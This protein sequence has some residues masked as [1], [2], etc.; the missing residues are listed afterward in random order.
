MLYT[1][2]MAGVFIVWFLLFGVLIIAKEFSLFRGVGL[3]GLGGL[4]GLG[5]QYGNSDEVGQKVCG[6]GGG[7][8]GRGRAW[9]KAELFR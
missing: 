4:G 9:W 1:G 7:G 8:V 5:G 2:A 6:G 3:W